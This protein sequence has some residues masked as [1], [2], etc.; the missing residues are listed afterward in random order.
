MML[1]LTSI[2]YSKKLHWSAILLLPFSAIFSFVVAVR[3]W[4]YQ[5]GLFKSFHFQVPVIVVGNITVGGTGKTPFVISLVKFLQDQGYRPGIVSR[6]VGG[7]E[8]TKARF[9]KA[10]DA[11]DDVGDEALLLTQKT[12]CPMV[13]CKDRVAAVRTLLNKTHCNI[14]ISD[15]GLQHYRLQRSLEIVMVDH[16]RQFG[17]Q[18][19]LPAG[20]LREPISRIKQAD[21]VV[22]NGGSLQDPYTLTLQPDEFVSI[23]TQAKIPLHGF[24]NKKIHAVSGIGH[25]QRFFKTLQQLG[26][27]LITHIFPDH[28]LYQKHEL[29]FSEKLP[30]VMTEKDAVKCA[31]FANDDYWYLN[32]IPKMNEKLEQS[33]LSKL[34]S[35]ETQENE[36]DFANVACRVQHVQRDHIR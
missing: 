12:Q 3:R 29:H 26:M 32:I 23:V 20:P 17:N 19:L 1:D 2:W 36:K 21:F 30:I 27:D 4:C 34:K 8:S 28:H 31:A 14:V 18:Y 33:I 7:S 6:G 5:R 25:P 24:A 13:V 9:V 22:V 11:A 16:E 35:L 15:D 10:T